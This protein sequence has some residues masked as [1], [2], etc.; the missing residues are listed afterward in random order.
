MTSGAFTSIL[1]D[2]IIVNRAE[3]QRKELPNVDVLAD[4]IKRVGLIHPVVIRRDDNTLVAGERRLEACRSLGHTHI[5]AQFL[6]ELDELTAH[7]VELEEN[8]KR[9][10]LPWPDECKAVA[11]FHRLQSM[12]ETDWSQEKTATAL[13]L[14]Q[15]DVSEKIKVA[16]ELESG[17]AL[18]VNAPRLSTA[19]GIVRRAESRKADAEALAIIAPTTIEPERPSGPIINADFNEWAPAYTGP[20]FNFIHCDF[21]YGINA[22]KFNQG[23]ASLHGGYAD[24]EDTYWRLCETMAAYLDRIAAPSA[25]FMFWFSM[26][27]YTETIEFFDRNTDIKFN[28]YPLIWTKSDNIGIIPDPE[29]GPRQIYETALFGSRG[30]R[31]IVRPTSNADFSPSTRDEHMS[32]KSEA[33]LRKFFTMFVDDST[34]FIDPT[35]GSGSSVRAACALGARHYVGL[36]LNPDFAE[37]AN[38]NFNK[39]QVNA[40]S[41][42]GV[43][44][45]QAGKLEA[46]K[47]ELA[48]D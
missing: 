5:N 48:A 41:T 13:G 2:S 46:D 8:I 24:T 27:Y 30:D 40:N 38:I 25:H 14:N 22:D 17:N 39:G 19:K 6:D 23:A 28:R 12:R 15:S 29:R 42:G 7:A 37:R 32:I 20:K 18:V 35:C 47:P 3:R 1:I 4:S 26:K 11:E 21:P 9:E 34:A 10:A 33:M 16:R 31:K 43:G 36:E 45:N 44:Q